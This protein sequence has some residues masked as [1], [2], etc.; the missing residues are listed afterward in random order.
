MQF[1]RAMAMLQTIGKNNNVGT[2]TDVN[3]AAALLSLISRIKV[4]NGSIIKV[5][6]T[7]QYDHYI[8]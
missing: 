2:L 8:R 6:T 3:I 1:R 7:H 5:Q 4:N